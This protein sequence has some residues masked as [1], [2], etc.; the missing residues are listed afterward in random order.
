[1]LIDLIAHLEGSRDIL[2]SSSAA[3]N[4]RNP[5][6][7]TIEPIKGRRGKNKT[8]QVVDSLERADWL[9]SGIWGQLGTTKLA[10]EELLFDGYAQPC[11]PAEYICRA[12]QQA[13]TATRSGTKVRQALSEGMT[14]DTPLQ[15][16]GPKDAAE[17]WA[18]PHCRFI[19]S[20][21][22]VVQRNRIMRTRLRIPCG[23]T[24]QVNL[25]LDDSIMDLEELKNILIDAGRRVGT[26]DY[27]PK[28]GRFF[29]RDLEII[30]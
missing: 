25:T 3:M 9:S 2:F 28:F 21:S 29:L 22:V 27:R 30:Q 11:L 14:A 8:E 19:D 23:W 17:M 16:D 4:P 26:G 18:D 5:I 15:Y 10:G 1:M 7:K 20:R 6:L 24:A 12:A 13:G